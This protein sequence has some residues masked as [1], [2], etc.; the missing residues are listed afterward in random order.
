MKH[1]R[2][3]SDMT[4]ICKF[5][6]VSRDDVSRERSR[7]IPSEEE[8]VQRKEY[9]Q[10][11]KYVQRE[12]YIKPS[13]KAGTR[14]TRIGSLNSR[15]YVGALKE[16]PDEKCLKLPKYNVIKATGPD[17]MK[18]FTVECIFGKYTAVGSGLPK[19]MA[20]QKAAERV[21]RKIKRLCK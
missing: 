20:N 17:H 1:K 2:E 10:R 6:P 13:F 16:Y 8:Y 21:Y 14:S 15:N 19:K 4:I 11:E 9:V 3:I 18:K 7:S 12:E 5:E